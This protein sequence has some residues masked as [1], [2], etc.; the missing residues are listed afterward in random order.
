M[1]WGE[2]KNIAAFGAAVPLQQ[3]LPADLHRVLKKLMPAE[4]STPLKLPSFSN[5]VT[6]VAETI[7]N[8]KFTNRLMRS[9][10]IR[11]WHIDNSKEAVD[12]NK[13]KAMMK[14]MH[15]TNLEVHLAYNKCKEVT[16]EMAD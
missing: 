16:P 3:P 15:Q 13:T 7:T 1:T 2:F 12:I 6:S 5:F 11:Q 14:Q 9:S 4:D 10:Y 8:K